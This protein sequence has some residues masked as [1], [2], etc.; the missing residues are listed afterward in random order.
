MYN[1]SRRI[2]ELGYK[3]KAPDKPPYW[4]ERKPETG[5]RLL[6]RANKSNTI[7]LRAET[8]GYIHISKL[9][10]FEIVT[11]PLRKGC[12]QVI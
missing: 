10:K 7:L 11:K 3:Y 5:I 4:S 2:R 1:T 6:N 9:D 8:F 12:F